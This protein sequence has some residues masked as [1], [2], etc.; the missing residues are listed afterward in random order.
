MS[1]GFGATDDGSTA[2]ALLLILRSGDVH[3]DR[4]D[5]TNQVCVW[6][7]KDYVLCSVFATSAYVIHSLNHNYADTNFLKP[8]KDR[9]AN[10]WK[11]K[12]IDWEEYGG[13]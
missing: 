2:R 7:H 1:Y 11:L 6:R 8:F 4:Q 10:W 3:K 13:K 5:T 12:F 9:D